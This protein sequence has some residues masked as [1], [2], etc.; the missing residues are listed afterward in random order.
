MS[1][2]LQPNGWSKYCSYSNSGKWNVSKWVELQMNAINGIM[3]VWFA[4]YGLFSIESLLILLCMGKRSTI[5]HH[6]GWWN[7]MAQTSQYFSRELW[8][9]TKKIPTSLLNCSFF[10][11]KLQY[12][13]FKFLLNAWQIYINEPSVCS[14]FEMVVCALKH[15]I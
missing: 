9:T 12:V 13:I 2:V 8:D 10:Q 15:K 11:S 6:Y 5:F 4:S 1:D 14:K 3:L 7:T